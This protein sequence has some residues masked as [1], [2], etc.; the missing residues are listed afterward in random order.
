MK[1]YE[2]WEGAQCNWGPECEGGAGAKR[3]GVGKLDARSFSHWSRTQGD[4][5]EWWEVRLGVWGSILNDVGL[6]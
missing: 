6:C 5:E 4:V 3:L 1:G 2:W